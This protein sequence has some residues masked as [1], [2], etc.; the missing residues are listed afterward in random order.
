MVSTT[1]FELSEQVFY[2]HHGSYCYRV[3]VGVS[4]KQLYK[5]T[6]DACNNEYWV[7]THHVHAGASFQAYA[8]YELGVYYP[9][10]TQSYKHLYK[11]GGSC[12]AVQ[13]VPRR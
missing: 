5:V 2:A 4:V 6:S 11:N 9:D 7:E 12:E 3:A 10:P 13:I 8:V 1:L